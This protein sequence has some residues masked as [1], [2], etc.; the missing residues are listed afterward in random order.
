MVEKTYGRGRDGGLPSASGPWLTLKRATTL[1]CARA[2]AW[3]ADA[4][5]ARAPPRPGRHAPCS[6]GLP[7]KDPRPSNHT[8]SAPGPAEQSAGSRDKGA[9]VDHHK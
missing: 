1:G 9:Q 3:E 8:M 2:V 5:G 4:V 6:L 7:T